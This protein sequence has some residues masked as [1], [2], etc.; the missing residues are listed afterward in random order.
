M[1]PKIY[2]SYLTATG[3]EDEMGGSLGNCQSVLQV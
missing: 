2:Y 1:E 3:M